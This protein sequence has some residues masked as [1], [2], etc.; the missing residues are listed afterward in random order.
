[1]DFVE[2]S[3][4]PET[5]SPEPLISGDG[6]HPDHVYIHSS[7]GVYVSDAELLQAGPD[8]N[9]LD[10][11]PDA[12]G[13][14]TTF[15]TESLARADENSSSDSVTSHPNNPDL[16]DELDDSDSVNEQDD[17]DERD[18]FEGMDG[19]GGLDDQDP[20]SAGPMD[21]DRLGEDPPPG[22]GL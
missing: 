9:M 6:S 4:Q 13:H 20:G 15:V 5:E 18:S 7:G 10:V 8:F 16:V 21:D 14:D 3:N 11:T 22:I 17:L 12:G 19:G 1:M 2:Q